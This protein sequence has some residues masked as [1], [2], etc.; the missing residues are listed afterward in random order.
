MAKE[1]TYVMIKPD[2][3]KQK[4]FSKICKVFLEND[5]DIIEIQNE[6]VLKKDIVREHY[7]HLLNESFYPDL[8]SF[9]LSGPVIPMIVYGEDAVSKVRTLIGP[10]NVKKAREESPNSI[11]AL[12]GNPNF[13]P[14]NVIHASDSRENAL[15]EIKRF[16]NKEMIQPCDCKRPKCKMKGMI[17]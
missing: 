7:S 11:R 10:T 15:I 2:G 1:V 13:G 14:S 4:L 9:M 3:V 8:E 17:L 12:Y 5:L 16:F 6:I